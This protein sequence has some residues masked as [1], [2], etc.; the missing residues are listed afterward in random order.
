[1]VIEIV[2][3]NCTMF[4]YNMYNV[5]YTRPALKNIRKRKSLLCA[6]HA[7]LRYVNIT[8]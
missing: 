2:L 1:M 5:Q 7:W 6:N 4:M 8:N 3:T